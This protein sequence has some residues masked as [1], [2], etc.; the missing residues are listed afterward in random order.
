MSRFQSSLHLHLRNP[1]IHSRVHKN[2][3]V[4]TVARILNPVPTITS[5]FSK[6]SFINILS[7]GLVLWDFRAKIVYTFLT[8][9]TIFLCLSRAS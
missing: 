3:P 4:D 8:F 5:C 1:K 2:L 6:I 9:P 7:R